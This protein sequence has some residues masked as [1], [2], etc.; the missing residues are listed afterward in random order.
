MEMR[1][2]GKKLFGFTYSKLNAWIIFFNYFIK[3]QILISEECLVS[4]A[5]LAGAAF[6]AVLPPKE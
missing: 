4:A 2:K 3:H 1:K 6:T 5:D